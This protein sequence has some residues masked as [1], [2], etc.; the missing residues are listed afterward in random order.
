MSDLVIFWF[1]VAIFA[2]VVLGTLLSGYTWFAREYEH[3]DARQGELEPAA[4]R[5][6]GHVPGRV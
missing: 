3:A 4:A 1:G 5:K 2:L 6:P